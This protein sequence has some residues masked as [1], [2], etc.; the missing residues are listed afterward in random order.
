MFKSLSN[1]QSYKTI[2]FSL[3]YVIPFNLKKELAFGVHS[4]IYIFFSNTILCVLIPK[5]PNN[6]IRVLLGF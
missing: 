4:S 5:K 3:L 1:S 6:S 2:L